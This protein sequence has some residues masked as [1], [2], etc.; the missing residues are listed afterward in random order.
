MGESSSRSRHQ[1][2]FDAGVLAEIGI[3]HGDEVDNQHLGL[4]RVNIVAQ[5]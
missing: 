1:P 2:H 4:S 3:D 5:R